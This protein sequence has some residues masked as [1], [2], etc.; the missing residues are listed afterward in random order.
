LFGDEPQAP[1]SA[2]DPLRSPFND[3]PPQPPADA[4]ESLPGAQP[5]PA[6]PTQAN[7]TA[8]TPGTTP[9]SPSATDAPEAGM[10]FDVGPPK[11]PS[12]DPFKDDPN[13]VPAPG[14]KTGARLEQAYRETYGLVRNE[15]TSGMNSTPAEAA[16][17]PEPQ[18]LRADGG[19]VDAARL[20][21]EQTEPNPLRQVSHPG[22]R[23]V[24]IEAVT[25]P[26]SKPVGTWRRNPLRGN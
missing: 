26:P 8:T 7:P 18:L 14:S 25:P 22:R 5:T 21:A 17:V 24:A 3:E 9:A 13:Q 11:M 20:P 16:D 15:A 1:P 23:T 12:D 6:V 10:P 4:E 2:A 19:K